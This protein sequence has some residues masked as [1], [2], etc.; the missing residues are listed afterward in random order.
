MVAG[1]L[2]TQRFNRDEYL[3]LITT[4]SPARDDD[5]GRQHTVIRRGPNWPKRCPAPV[6]STEAERSGEISRRNVA[7]HMVAGGLST[8]RFIRAQSLC[9]PY[10]RVSPL[11]MTMSAGSI[12]S[13]PEG[14]IGQNDALTA[15]RRP[16]WG[17]VI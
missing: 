16:A 3:S 7:R 4:G 10:R 13:F 9:H 11:E 1:D 2:S 8:L 14:Q 12:Q 5:S 17:S 15:K 6:I